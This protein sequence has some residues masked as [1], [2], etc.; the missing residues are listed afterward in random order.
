MLGEKIGRFLGGFAQR[1][2]RIVAD[3]KNTAD[4]Q[5]GIEGLLDAQ[6][7]LMDLYDALETIAI[8]QAGDE[9]DV[10]S[11]NRVRGKKPQLRGESMRM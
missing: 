9:D 3:K 11:D 5:R 10:G 7:S 8:R 1:F 6:Y 4:Y 2:A